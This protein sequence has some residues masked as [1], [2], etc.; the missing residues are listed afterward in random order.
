M[1]SLLRCGRRRGRR[2]AQKYTER[3]IGDVDGF[4]ILNAKNKYKQRKKEENE[5]D[6]SAF[7]IPEYTMESVFITCGHYRNQKH[8]CQS[9]IEMSPHQTVSCE[10]LM[11]LG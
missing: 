1:C 6:R 5:N 10:G 3:F 11:L 4:P 2:Y 9:K 8:D 7:H